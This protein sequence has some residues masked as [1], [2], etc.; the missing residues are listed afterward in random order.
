MEY[1]GYT[2]LIKSNPKVFLNVSEEENQ[3]NERDLKLMVVLSFA[4]RKV[5]NRFLFSI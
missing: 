1:G 4:A 2:E 5:T 3:E